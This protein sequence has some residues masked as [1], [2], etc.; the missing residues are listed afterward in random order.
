MWRILELRQRRGP[1]VARAWMGLG[2]KYAVTLGVIVACL[3]F[4]ACLGGCSAVPRDGMVGVAYSDGQVVMTG[5]TTL[6]P[7][8]AMMCI[9]AQKFLPIPLPDGWTPAWSIELVP[10]K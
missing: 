4:I 10:P 7:N 8:E 5:V 3:L 6:D 2:I 9:T 1:T